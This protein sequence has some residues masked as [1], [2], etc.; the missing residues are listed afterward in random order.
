M[1][2][3][4]D[5]IGAI[6]R[7]YGTSIAQLALANDLG[8]QKVLRVGQSLIV[9]MSGITPP[10][11]ASKNVSAAPVRKTTYIVRPGD[12]LSKIA[13]TFHTSVE[14]LKAWNHL[15]STRLA[16]GEKLVVAEG[17]LQTT[18]SSPPAKKLVHQVRQGETLGRIATTYKTSVD[19]IL[20]WNDANDLSVLHPGDR[21]TIFLGENNR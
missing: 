14:K 21:I 3:K 12:T 8:N 17:T 19:A 15:R 9:P 11:P 20:S 18:S 4:G 7:K 6:A 5:T 16:V 10:Q 13:A 2:R 1:V